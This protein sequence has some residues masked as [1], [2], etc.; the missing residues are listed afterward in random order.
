MKSIP[1]VKHTTKTEY[2]KICTDIKSNVGNQD[3]FLQFKLVMNYQI[4]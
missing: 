2:S 1:G 3:I 4:G